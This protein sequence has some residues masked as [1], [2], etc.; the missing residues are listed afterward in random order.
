MVLTFND[1]EE[2]LFQRIMSYVNIGT[3]CLAVVDTHKNILRFGELEINESKRII[4][5]KN[6]EIEL[7]FIEFE[8]ILLER[9]SAKSKSMILSGKNNIPVTIILL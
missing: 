9:F 5:K 7:T 8:I 4:T 2:D 1:N 3:K 6:S